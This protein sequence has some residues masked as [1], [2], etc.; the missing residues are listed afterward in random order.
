MIPGGAQ[1]LMGGLLCSKKL[2]L[3]TCW[4][5]LIKRFILLY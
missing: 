1:Q 5:L 4:K 3:E 2:E